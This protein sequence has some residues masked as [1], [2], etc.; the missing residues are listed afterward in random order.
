MQS[1]CSGCDTELQRRRSPAQ[2][3]L[4]TFWFFYSIISFWIILLLIYSFYFYI[5]LILQYFHFGRY[6]SATLSRSLQCLNRWIR[7]SSRSLLGKGQLTPVRDDNV[8]LPVLPFYT[9]YVTHAVFALGCCCRLH[10]FAGQV[11][12]PILK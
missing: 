2:I 10:A 1:W 7:H 12:F 6:K 4:N 5:L 9:K 3:P 8:Y 11:M